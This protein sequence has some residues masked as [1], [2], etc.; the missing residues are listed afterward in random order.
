MDGPIVRKPIT[1]PDVFY[2]RNRFLKVLANRYIIV[3]LSLGSI[4]GYRANDNAE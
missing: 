2:V 1:T 3:L 4:S